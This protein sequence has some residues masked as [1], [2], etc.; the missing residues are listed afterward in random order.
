PVNGGLRGT[1]FDLWFKLA[2]YLEAE[3]LQ[4][5]KVVVLFDSWD[6]QESVPMSFTDDYL[7]CLAAPILQN[8]D[9]DKFFFLPLP[10]HDQLPV[11]IDAVRKT[12]F[13]PGHEPQTRLQSIKGEIKAWVPASYRVYRYLLGKDIVPQPVL[14]ASKES[15]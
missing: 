10:P 4:I 6:F 7:R 15:E 5:D 8:C 13:V 3:K 14:P 2:Q 12:R 11:W 9:I 1:G